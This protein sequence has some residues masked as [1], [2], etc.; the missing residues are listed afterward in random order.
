MLILAVAIYICILLGIAYFSLKKKQTA[1][2]FMLGSRGLNVWLTALAA[3]ASDMSMWIFLGYPPQIY[4]KGLS[5]CP[6]AI[7]LIVFM[8]LNWMVVARKLREQT[9]HYSSLTLS[10][11]FESRFH[12]TSGFFRI[13]TTL[14]TFIFFAVYISAGLQGLALVLETYFSLPY[15]WGV[16][17]GMA[18][19][20][21]YLLFG[22]YI[23][24]AWTDLFQGCFLFLII[25]AFPLYMI[26][27]MGGW[28]SFFQKIPSN[29]LE[30]LPQSTAIS[31]ATLVFTFISYGLG[32]FGQ[33]HILTKFMGIKNPKKI[34]IS[35]G[36]G[37][38]W[39]I[40]VLA[41]ATLIGLVA[42]PYFPASVADPQTIFPTMVFNSLNPF[43]A[44]LILCAMLGATMT[45]IDS[46]VLVLSSLFTEDIY[47][48]YCHREASSRKLLYVSRMSIL[49]IGLTA[50][51]IA[52][53]RPTTVFGL[54]SYAWYGL[55]A[56]FGPL[57]I[58]SLF[59]T[60]LNKQGAWTGFIL[61][62]TCS[63]LWPWINTYIP[64]E[65]PSIL[66]GFFINAFATYGVSIITGKRT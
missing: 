14:F 62:S 16:I 45:T 38:S 58:L 35:M 27:T 19:T 51:A 30:L 24:L 3:H 18:F 29:A 13:A 41:A 5:E 6:I 22:G 12:D 36:I 1:T 52:L 25:L 46:Q 21:P 44:G 65:I 64:L 37:M 11:Y 53:I 31:I 48:K 23:T 15:V 9:E 10:S 7:G 32:Y 33:P 60:R 56:T 54:V 34:P 59:S 43:L 28:E 61:G 20:L 4:T 17:L 63:L 66:P 49:V 8:F 42:I 50:I 40:L 2:D 55:G 26:F 39:Q 57:I 47:K